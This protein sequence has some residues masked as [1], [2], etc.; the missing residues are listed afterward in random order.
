MELPFPHMPVANHLSTGR[1]AIRVRGAV[2]GVD[3]EDHD[4]INWD[5]R[6]QDSAFEVPVYGFGGGG[7]GYVAA[8]ES[9]DTVDVPTETSGVVLVA[10]QTEMGVVQAGR[11]GDGA[12]IGKRGIDGAAEGGDG[13]GVAGSDLYFLEG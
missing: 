5:F 1:V 13:G 3:V 4:P 7:G 9:A 11:G 10:G 12:I 2:D 8:D 6:D